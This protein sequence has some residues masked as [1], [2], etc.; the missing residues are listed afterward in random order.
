MQSEHTNEASDF[1]F[2]ALN[3]AINYRQ[4]LLKEFKPNLKGRVLEIGSGIGQMSAELMAI[5]EI[6][7]LQCIEPN[8][9]YCRKLRER[10]PTANV[11]R[12]TVKDVT[13]GP[14][15]AIVS[16]NVLEHIEDDMGE[17]AMYANVLRASKGTLNLF[18]PARPE[19]Y[20]P[21]DKDFGHFRRYSK[22]DI[23]KKL[24]AGGFSIEYLRYFNFAGYFLWWFNFRLLG[25]RCFNRTMVR[26][27]DRIVFPL[28]Y[29]FESKV[30][31][32][33]LGQSIVVIAKVK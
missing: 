5:P 33:P 31:F 27:F 7:Y 11:L 25:K 19:I 12:G 3:E 13:G 30:T 18:I 22:T 15:H 4:A 21:I 2:S 16:I 1:E 24:E 26:W 14:W 23:R 20:A 10:L 8:D 6:E 9:R 28:V 29:F 17:L 32:P